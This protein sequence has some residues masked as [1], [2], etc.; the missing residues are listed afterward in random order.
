MKKLEKIFKEN[1][2]GEEW[3]FTVIDGLPKGYK[4]YKARIKVDANF[5]ANQLIL[6]KLNEII[7][8]L[9]NN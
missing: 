4:L 2:D 8:T 5:D 6:N 7:D 1:I 3:Y 9:N